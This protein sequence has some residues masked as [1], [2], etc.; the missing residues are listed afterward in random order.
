VAK[1]ILNGSY[2]YDTDMKYYP[3]QNKI[4]TMCA[5][6]AEEMQFYV[7]VVQHLHNYIF[8][9]V[10]PSDSLIKSTKLSIPAFHN[11]LMDRRYS[12]SKPMWSNAGIIKS[13]PIRDN[14]ESICGGHMFEYVI[15]F[16]ALVKGFVGKINSFKQF[17]PLLEMGSGFGGHCM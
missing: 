11:T 8:T 16:D 3:S 7:Q 6:N 2:G 1:I 14:I 10:I 4:L 5:T 12:M 17:Q 9:W 15:F 13:I